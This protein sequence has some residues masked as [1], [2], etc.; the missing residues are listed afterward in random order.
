MG[1]FS[2]LTQ[3]FTEV[4]VSNLLCNY[5]KI[6]AGPQCANLK[7][8][9]ANNVDIYQLWVE[10]AH[11]EGVWDLREARRW[12]H[13]FPKVQSMVTPQSV[14]RWL[15]EQGLNDIVSTVENTSGGNEWLAWQVNRFRAGLWEQS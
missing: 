13:M 10:N 7:T 14:K 5:F 3:G 2:S 6:Y 9:I 15:K 1:I 8:A 4:V 12:T 11:R